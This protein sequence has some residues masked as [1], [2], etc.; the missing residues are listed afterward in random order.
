MKRKAL[1]IGAP[2]SSIPGVNADMENYKGFLLGPTGG[3]WRPDEI[4]ILKNPSAVTVRAALG[5]LKAADYSFAVFAGHGAYSLNRRTTFVNIN[6]NE[7]MDV[8][9]FKVGAAKHT[10]IIDACRNHVVEPIVEQ[11]AMLKAAMDSYTS[12]DRARQIFDDHVAKCAP[13]FAGLYS[14]ADNESAGDTSKGGLFS[15]T[16]LTVAWDWSENRAA[17]ASVLQIDQAID[18]A[19]PLVAA[20]SGRKQNP[21]YYF[22]RSSPR[23][24]FAVRP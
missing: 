12:V 15:H 10:L 16:L 6:S 2:D 23:F 24:P 4:T 22:T 19:T 17:S 9:D 13:G 14:C 8:D 20:R 1:I 5:A 11:R 7:T 21:D 18:A 3:L